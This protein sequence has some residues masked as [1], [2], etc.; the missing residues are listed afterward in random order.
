ML[1]YDAAFWRYFKMPRPLRV[2]MLAPP[3]LAMPVKGYAGIERVIQSLVGELRKLNV[4]VV[5]FAN[6]ERK[7]KG[8][9]TH[10]LYKT[11]QYAEI[12]RPCYESSPILGAHVQFSL[13]K[14]IEDGKFDVIHDHTEYLG[15][16]VLAWASMRQDVPPIVHTKHGPPF[17]TDLMNDQGIP[18]NTPYWRQLGGNMGKLYMVGISDTL[19]ALAP[20]ELRSRIL[21]TVYNA[22]DVDEFPFVKEKKNYFYTLAR[23]NRDKAQHVAA[24]L[25]AK[26]G[27]R[28]RMAGSV[29]GIGSARKL[30]FEL[31]NP[32][33]PYRNMTD[34]RYYSDRVFPYVIRYPKITYSGDI[35]GTKKLKLMSEA[36]ALLF[37]IDWEEPFGMVVIE[38][39]ACGTPVVAMNRG[40]MPEI[41]E[42][43]VTGFLANDEKEFAEYMERIG[44][45]DPVACRKSVE[46][47]FGAARMASEY[48][49]RYK[50][51]IALEKKNKLPLR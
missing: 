32:L 1:L 27:Y 24:K 14:I 6:G 19:M 29:A 39:M 41:I 37:P 50:K 20:R 7:L 42:H 17:S 16:Q 47:K 40:A 33:S 51:V 3:W 48:L 12:H 5:M 34:F 44:E 9:K 26:K 45:I 35:S 10:A 15:P 28:L 49:K 18:D 46:H 23:F 2:A 43:G 11:E 25:C 8:V 21:P 36:K 4:E 22:I 38:A 13:N 30:L 31:A